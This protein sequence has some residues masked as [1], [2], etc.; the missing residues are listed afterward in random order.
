MKQIDRPMTG[1][2]NGDETPTAANAIDDLY[3]SG[4]LTEIDAYFAGFMSR[5]DGRESRPL[6][7]AAALLSRS[8]GHGHVCL[9]LKSLDR[10]LL[11]AAGNH[12]PVTCPGIDDWTT[13]LKAS[14]VVG[15]P[16]ERRPLVLDDSNR[17]YLY[18]YWRYEQDLVSAIVQRANRTEWV[19]PTLEP[20]GARNVF[21]R[22]FPLQGNNTEV[23]WQK[24]AALAALV[25]PFCVISGG[26]G[27]GKTHTITRILAL[28]IELAGDEGL[29][30]ALAAPT[31]K[32]ASRL[33]DAIR[34]VRETLDCP[35]AVKDRI[36]AEAQTL[37]RLLS[38]IAGTPYFYFD[39]DHPLPFDVVFVDEASMV[40]L[41]LLSKLA[42]ALPE[43]ARMVLVGDK[44]Q[45][46]SV[47]AG[48][49]LGDICDRG[50]PYRF[51][52]D[53]CKLARRVIDTSLPSC[54]ASFDAGMSDCIVNLF[55]SYR[56]EDSGGIGA[57]S[58]AVN[59]GDAD[60]SL[61]LLRTADESR[62]GWRPV[63]S[64]RELYR[65][66]GEFITAG[67][68]EY[69]LSED[70]RLALTRFDRFRILCAVNRG[71]FGVE[72]LNRVVQE[73]L[74]RQGLIRPDG[75]RSDDQWYAGRPIMVTAN[76]YELGVFN[77]DVGLVLPEEKATGPL[78][79]YFPDPAGGVR[80][81]AP[82]RLSGIETGYAMS[83][84]KSQGSEFD[85]VHVIL[86][87]TDSAVLSRELIYTA[88]TRA[89]SR[90]IIWGM[91]DV[92]AKALARK[93][94]RHSGLR[95]ALWGKIAD[96]DG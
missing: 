83:I 63:S 61:E 20:A 51:S 52:A 56:F 49:A 66:L 77:G 37:H 79:A 67:Y 59:C 50:R 12:L 14:P 85:Q 40:D 90:V 1:G 95:E 42:V 54:D 92:L 23:D 34:T 5:L 88:V 4:F 32:A 70:P 38:P 84:H 35:S 11:E 26:P 93:I 78:M 33:G 13:H 69:L 3:R 16:G 86:P 74:H 57:L 96:D 10:S 44:D 80:R 22:L 6:A 19:S 58:R 27:T 17:L 41:A 24:V 94:V 60:A 30:I 28:M 55:K 72:S 9:D 47:A 71:P 87:D 76:D 73:V 62:I 8:S 53:F 45:L 21:E 7:L 64:I 91:E 68:R 31:G 18:R 46:A 81:I 82:A 75:D 89:R 39:R 36:P 15:S 25:K 48:A 65:A 29:K 2:R 43:R